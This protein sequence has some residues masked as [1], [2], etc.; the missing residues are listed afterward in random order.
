ML[1]GAIFSTANSLYQLARDYKN[2]AFSAFSHVSKEPF[3]AWYHADV[4]IAI[5][6]KAKHCYKLYAS[7]TASGTNLMKVSMDEK[8]N[9]VVT[10]KTIIDKAGHIIGN[11]NLYYSP[12]TGC[13]WKSDYI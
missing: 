5:S 4:N 13:G 8:L 9:L 12:I 11:T 2:F 3:V 10:L 1:A 6:R 7:V